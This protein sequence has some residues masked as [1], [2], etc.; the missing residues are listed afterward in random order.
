M[1]VI[2][3]LF[4]RYKYHT[5]KTHEQTH[6]IPHS[7]RARKHEGAYLMKAIPETRSARYII[8]LPFYYFICT[9]DFVIVIVFLI[10]VS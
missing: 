4:R 9:F 7:S 3:M 2:T 5:V 6:V 8:Y 10:V 1:N